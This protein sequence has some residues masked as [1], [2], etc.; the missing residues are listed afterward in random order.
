VLAAGEIA[1]LKKENSI[2]SVFL[3]F[4]S[5]LCWREIYF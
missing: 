4:Q 3:D 5:A 1:D 2:F